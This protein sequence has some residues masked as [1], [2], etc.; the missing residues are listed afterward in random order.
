M[1]ADFGQA[2]AEKVNTIVDTGRV[3]C[4]MTSTEPQIDTN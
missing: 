2:I 1:Y 3:Y 4:L